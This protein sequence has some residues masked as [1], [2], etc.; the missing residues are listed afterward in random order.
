MKS[1]S[2]VLLIALIVCPFAVLSQITVSVSCGSDQACPSGYSFVVSQTADQ[3]GNTKAYC[4]S[5]CSMKAISLNIWECSQNYAGE[6]CAGATGGAGKVCFS[7]TTNNTITSWNPSGGCAN[8]TTVSTTCGSCPSGTNCGSCGNTGSLGLCL[9]NSCTFQN[10][11]SINK[12]CP[13]GGDMFGVGSNLTCCNYYSWTGGSATG[14]ICSMGTYL[15]AYNA[16]LADYLGINILWSAYDI[17]RLTLLAI[18]ALFFAANQ[19]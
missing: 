2:T 1:T 3:G 12:N 6:Y 7:G 13:T 4:T 18:I 15:G 17:S 5:T 10:A 14:G 9:Q 11:T 19:L 8:T 16:Y